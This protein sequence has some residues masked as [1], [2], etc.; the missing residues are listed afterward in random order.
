[1]NLKKVAKYYLYINANVFFTRGFTRTMICDIK[2]KSWNFIS[3]K[4]YECILLFRELPIG[5]VIKIMS[6]ETEIDLK[7]FI[8]F[9]VQNDYGEIV[10][11]ISLFPPIENSWDSPHL[12]ENAIIDRNTNSKYSLQKIANNL[13]TLQCRNVQIRFFS[14]ISLNCIE[15]TL[16]LF[17][18]RDF[19]SLE[20]IC[21]YSNETNSEICRKIGEKFPPVS[22]VLYNAPQNEFFES[23]LKDIYAGIGYVQCVKQHI[24]SAKDCGII[25]KDSFI[26]PTSVC[27]YM[28]GVLCNKC[29]NRKI[30]IDVNGEIKNCPSMTFNYGNIR[31]KELLEI[32]SLEEYK[33]YWYL[34][35]DKIEVCKDCEYRNVCNDCRAFIS[36][37]YSKPVKCRYNPYKGIWI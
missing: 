7:G 3:N 22:F 37:K 9:L 33:S 14:C 17:L 1:M 20:I 5:K 2:K 30:S 29:L 24:S 34:T 4:Y 26:Y 25:N 18:N 36:N 35:K 15:N 12:I 21:K 16:S 13:E 31:D 8:E 11:D 32:I 6:D 10:P 19:E 23:R 28:E 27:S